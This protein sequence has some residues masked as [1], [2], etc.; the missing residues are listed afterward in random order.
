MLAFRKL[1]RNI[2]SCVGLYKGDIVFR[3][4]AR[5]KL[6]EKGCLNP[7]ALIPGTYV[8]VDEEDQIE[9]NSLDEEL[10]LRQKDKTK[11]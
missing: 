8:K 9:S 10:K 5:I 2:F 3:K 7:Q 4:P 11:I 6:L 1:I